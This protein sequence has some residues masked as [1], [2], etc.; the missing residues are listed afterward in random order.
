MKTNAEF[1]QEQVKIPQQVM[2][3]S[4]FRSLLGKTIKKLK[5]KI[6]N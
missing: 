6:K 2:K 3:N 1:L 5:L 4:F